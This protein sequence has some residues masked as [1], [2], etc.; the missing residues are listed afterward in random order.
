VYINGKNVQV[1]SNSGGV[2]TLSTQA[3]VV[4]TSVVPGSAS[5]TGIAGQVAWDTGYFYVCVDTDTW[6][7]TPLS[8]W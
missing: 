4:D 5:D 3:L 8:T 6:K 7:R 2:L 1:S